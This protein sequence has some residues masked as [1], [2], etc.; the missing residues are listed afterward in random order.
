[1]SISTIEKLRQDLLDG[2][3]E[4]NFEKADGSVRTAH[5]TMSTDYVPAPKAPKNPNMSRPVPSDNVLF[6]DLDALG[7][8]SCKWGRVIGWK[9]EEE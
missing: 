8:R 2:V 7:F 3:V 9:G 1:M 6:W 5:A 4:L